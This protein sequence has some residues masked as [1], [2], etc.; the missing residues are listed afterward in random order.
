MRI[1]QPMLYVGLGGTGC[2]IGAQLERRIREELCG[3]DGTELRDRLS[4][5]SMRPYQLPSCLQFVYADLNDAELDK[6]RRRAVPSPEHIEA[7][8]LTMHR[9]R[10]LVPRL[11]T[12]P[13][14]ARSLRTNEPQL[15]GDWLPPRAGEP[16]VA[17]LSR[18]AGQ[19]PTIGRAAL[20][21]TCRHGIEPAQRPIA[22]AVRN[23][24]NS[25][26]HLSALGGNGKVEWIDVFVSFS[27]AGG[28][29]AGIFY[30]YLH[31]I[32]NAIARSNLKAQIYPLVIMPSAFSEGLGGGRSAQLNS[33]RALLDLFRLVDDQNGQG[34]RTQLDDIGLSGELS[35]AYPKDGVITIKP[36]T[37]QTA[38]LFSRPEAVE[39][40]DL[41]RSI[42]SLVLSLV[43]TQ[44]AD[45]RSG[46][47]TGERL[48]QSFADDFINRGVNRESVS[49]T[50]VGNRGVSTSLVASMTVPVDDLADIIS[51]RL[52]AEAVAE[53]STPPPGRTESNR[54]LIERFFLG[55]NLEPLRTRTRVEFT[56]PPAAQGADAITRALRARVRS[57]EAGLNALDRSLV[58]QVT[59]L[60]DGFDPRRAAELL[61]G[62][63]DLFRLRRVVLG[64]TGLADRADQLGFVGVVEGRRQEPTPPEGIDL[65]PPQP[66]NIRNRLL[67]K[68][69][70][71]DPAVQNSI[72][73]QDAWY[74]YRT[75]RA[76][77]MAWAEQ[78]VRWERVL[79][80]VSR[81]ITAIT[82]QF[83]EYAQVNDF[84][85]RA[86]ELYRP[87]TGVSY[88]LPPQGLEPFYQATL[89][90][91]VA[92]YVARGQLKPT[93]TAA[94][95]VNA[96]LEGA[97]WRRAYQLGIE[98][99]PEHAVTVVRDALKQAVK[100]QFR[101][102]DQG[103]QPLLP[104][105]ADLL[106]A[107]AGKESGPVGDDDLA[108][109]RQ[110]IVGLVPGGFTP[111][112]NGDL[113]VLISYA[114]PT[115][116][117][118]RDPAIENYLRQHLNLPREPN[119]TME[120]RP[121]TAESIVVVLFRTSMSVTDVRE[122][123]EV[124]GYWS[125]AV[126]EP[127]PED[128]LKWRQR[129]GH[130][131]G[132]LMTT[133]AHRV[134]I[135]HRLLCV[136]WNGQ[137]ELLSGTPQ[138]PER[139]RIRLATSD[140]VSMTLFLESFDGASSWGGIL[141]AYEEWT[142]AGAAEGVE[143]QIRR[144][145]CRRLM[146]TLP[147]GVQSTPVEPHPLYQALLDG[148]AAQ[149]ER[150][151]QLVARMPQSS[152]AQLLRDFWALTLPEA[153]DVPFES[154]NDPV[155]ANLSDLPSAVRWA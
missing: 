83:L 17:P 72:A 65:Q 115:D 18:G 22:D 39:R 103:E 31:L 97:A 117:A 124:L 42:V 121:I 51:S 1:Y 147:N 69:R 113:K 101:R 137:I 64:H 144:D 131:F 21:E 8:E 61:L 37:V 138:S 52:L 84:D 126:R 150:T 141:R 99:G 53:L 78:T 27:V 68:A 119:M 145:F 107:S 81:Q 5:S 136:L 123:R 59:N 140:S 86:Q 152:H 71:T 55:A 96:I 10:E 149:A 91:F 80:T 2:L 9:V 29:G 3:P 62:E 15:V 67:A 120:F 146:E 4:A 13:E 109:F 32:A 35:V 139:I 66:G 95:V 74:R 135:L 92:Y 100:R 46:V 70:W 48:F 90:R 63:V 41:H 49:V 153:L 82:D 36:S 148:A 12:Y 85:A 104:A 111:Q 118:G 25:G 93:A 102:T 151:T 106:A 143:A 134:K 54:A 34:A 6:V 125:R 94:R 114:S 105:L 50:G 79:R 28:T 58:E 133:E 127:R 47:R 11:D 112:G 56:E 57:M 30:D 110:N 19:L 128:F 87:R 14:V 155:R 20:Y 75:R 24:A 154:V 45:E 40:D 60:V 130:N 23:I 16:H 98:H 122:L 38:F 132:Y 33:G 142:I 116:D 108:M 88:L 43:A 89:R 77:H 44:Q 7:A 26:G 76:W 129:L 73:A